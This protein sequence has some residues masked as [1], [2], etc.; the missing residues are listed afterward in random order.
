MIRTLARNL[1]LFRVRL[2]VG[3]IIFQAIPTLVKCSS[4]PRELS[5]I[6]VVLN[7]KS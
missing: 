2:P 4:T 6:K 3:A 1:E 7:Y 5:A